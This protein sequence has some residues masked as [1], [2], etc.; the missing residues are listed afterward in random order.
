MR[1]FFDL[2]QPWHLVV[3]ALVA[4]VYFGGIGLFSHSG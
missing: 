4:F 1:H 2:I 3:F